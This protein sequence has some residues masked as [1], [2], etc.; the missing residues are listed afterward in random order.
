MDTCHVSQFPPVLLSTRK[1]LIN[2]ELS[3]LMSYF[4]PRNIFDVLMNTDVKIDFFFSFKY[5]FFS[6]CFEFQQIRQRVRTLHQPHEC[7]V[8][9]KQTRM[10]YCTTTAAF[11]IKKHRRYFKLLCWQVEHF[12]SKIRP[13]LSDGFLG[14]RIMA[15]IFDIK[16]HFKLL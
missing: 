14:I 16:T 2:T 12:H 7:F 3:M 4:T 11:Y 1:W 5:F 15:R 6:A 10:A 9:S 13:I 8:R